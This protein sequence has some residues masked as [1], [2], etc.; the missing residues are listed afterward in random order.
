MNTR[1]KTVVREF[2]K[3]NRDGVRKNNG[4]YAHLMYNPNTNDIWVDEF[5]AFNH[6]S[7]VNYNDTSIINLGNIINDAE[8]TV[9]T[10]TEFINN[11]QGEV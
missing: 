3:I 11:L 7:Y 6:G 9:E 5:A 1:I 2:N 8:I 10:V 4:H